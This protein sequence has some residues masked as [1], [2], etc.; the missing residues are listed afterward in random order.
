M[1]AAVRRGELVAQIVDHLAASLSDVDKQAIRAAV[2]RAAKTLPPLTALWQ[3]LAAFPDALTSGRAEVPLVLG[4]LAYAL[5]DAGA[6]GIRPPGCGVCGKATRD[7]R[8]V[9]GPMLV[10]QSCRQDLRREV[11]VRCGRLAR[12]NA[13]EADGPVCNRCYLRDPKRHEIC[14]GCGEA[15]RVAYRDAEGQPWCAPL[16]VIT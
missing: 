9:S 14:R 4:R 1:N 6:E 16:S 3:H 13:R 7:L 11:C 2:D 15:H 5:V 10:C 8:G 12:V